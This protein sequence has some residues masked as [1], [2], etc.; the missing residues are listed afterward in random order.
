MA[1]QTVTAAQ[2][3]VAPSSSER[4]DGIFTVPSSSSTAY[5]A[6]MP[7]VAPPSALACTSG[8]GS[9]PG[10]RAKKLP[11]TLSPTFTRV[12]PEPTSTTSPAPSDSG[13]TFSFDGMR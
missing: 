7:S 4:C 6:S 11:A 1:C 3:R 9:P 13:M 12:T 8:G 5:S 2:G 10:Q